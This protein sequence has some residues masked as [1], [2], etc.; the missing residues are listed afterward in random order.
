MPI[1]ARLFVSYA[2]HDR[3]VAEPLLDLLRR[4][5]QA[6]R[7]TAAEAWDFHQLLV[8]ER[9]HARIQ[10]EIESA[11]FGLLLVSPAFLTSRYILGHELR[12]FVGEGTKPVFPVGLVP[13]DFERHDL[14]GIEAHQVFRL[15]GRFFSELRGPRR[16]A[17]ALALFQQIDDRLVRDLATRGAKS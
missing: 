3:D 5:F 13:L 16:Q 6:A 4:H 17:F 9:W 2:E 11:Q 15:D 8:G 7:R 14:R 10:D 1:P 12:H